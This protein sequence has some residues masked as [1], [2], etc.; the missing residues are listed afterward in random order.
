MNK[1]IIDLETRP[2]QKFLD[3]KRENIKPAGN[4]KDPEKIQADIEDKLNGIKKSMSLDHDYNE[5]I[6]IGVR[7]KGESKTFRTVKE[8][9]EWYNPIYDPRDTFIGYNL[10]SFDLPTLIK[11]G[12]REKVDLPYR[13]LFSLTKKYKVDNCIDLQEIVNFNQPWKSL[14]LLLQIYFG[15]AKKP[16]NFETASDQEIIEHNL[17]DLVQTEMIYNLFEPIIN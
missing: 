5:I 10:K 12:L 2:N 3:L 13:F 6:C 7:M 14:D 15:I 1:I 4:L 17:D 11:S 16:I 9:A 8:F